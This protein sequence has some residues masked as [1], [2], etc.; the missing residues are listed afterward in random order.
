MKTMIIIFILMIGIL[1]CD[2][3]WIDS[4]ETSYYGEFFNSD[5][6]FLGTSMYCFHIDD[7]LIFNISKEDIE[8]MTEKEYERFIFLFI[9]ATEHPHYLG[10]IF[11]DKISFVFFD[12]KYNARISYFLETACKLLLPEW[13]LKRQIE[14]MK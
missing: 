5:S 6:L 9:L 7:S 10:Y 11:K 14:E 3:E 13:I 12:R 4:D 2:N 1:W 8:K